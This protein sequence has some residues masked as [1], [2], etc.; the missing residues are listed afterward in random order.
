[1][2]FALIAFAIFSVASASAVK[3]HQKDHP[4]GKIIGM[5][6]ELKVKSQTQQ[7]EE[8]VLHQ[9]F[10]YWC[11]T[12][13]KELTTEITKGKEK[14]EVLE[15][16]IEAKTKEIEKLTADLELLEKQIE[17]NGAASAK[18]D[19]IRE[20]EADTYK[21]ADADFAE[22]LDAIQQCIDALE[23]TKGD[24]DSLLAQKS[25][26][27]V[28]NLASM[29]VSDKEQVVISSFLQEMQQPKKPKAKVYSFKSQGVIEL[30]KKLLE[31]FETDK[32]ET[33]K[34]ETNAINAYNM[35]KQAREEAL[36]AFEKSKKEKEEIKGEAE[37]AKTE[38][39]DD[40]SSTKDDLAANEKSLE[41]VTQECELEA[42]DYAKRSSAREGEITAIG[43]AIKILAKVG[44]VR[45]PES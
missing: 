38:A 45:A 26:K 36:A 39:E 34:A 31:K 41:D 1:M 19:K 9:K 35:A 16:T 14:I 15:D 23:S 6:E 18:A 28:L 33:T 10:Q 17:E 4:I 24:V 13:T 30:L 3:D 40:L 44:G 42:D 27:K 32:L 29:L 22:T 25:V 43:M 37:K 2:K 8:A 5:L 21:Q 11:K 12:T 20:E 7:E